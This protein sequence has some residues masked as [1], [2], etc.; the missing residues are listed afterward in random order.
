MKQKKK[1]ITF[2]IILIGFIIPFVPYLVVF[3]MFYLL[4]PFAITFVISLIY[5]IINLV[6]Q[7]TNTRKAL[8]VFS[9]LPIF[10]LSQLVPSFTVDKIQRFRSDRIIS[11]MEKIKSETEKLPEKYELVG[12]IEYIKIKGEESFVIKYPRGFM[13]TEIYQSKHTHWRSYGWND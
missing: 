1:I 7:N 5:I 2:S 11:K 9:L 6:T 3:Q 4:V 13:V 12:G 8:F 10:I